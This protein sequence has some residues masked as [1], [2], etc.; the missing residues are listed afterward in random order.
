MRYT[1]LGPSGLRVSEIC[2]GTMSF[3]D[4][5]G[6]GADEKE[7]HRILVAYA[8]A[9]GNFI[10]IAN[11]YHEG[12]SEEIVGSFLGSERDRCVVASKYTL[13]M[14]DGDPNAAGNSR[15]N[16]R[17]SVE[18]SLR[19]LRTDYLDVLWVHAWDYATPVEEVMRGLEDLVRAG[20][21]NYVALSDAPAW[22]ASQANTLAALRGWSPFVA[23]QLEYSLI[24]RTGER[25]LLPVAEAFG[26]AVTAWAP[27][28]G[29]VL[30]GKYSRGSSDT[31]AD[32][33]RAE[34]NQMRLTERNLEIAHQVDAV[35]D[36]LS[37][38][39]AQVAIAWVR[40]RRERIIPIVGVRTL[41]QLEDI[42]GLTALELSAE[43]ISRLDEVS[44]IEASHT[45][46]SN[47]HLAR[48]STAT[49]S[50]GSSCRVRHRIGGRRRR[51]PRTCSPRSRPPGYS[52]R[53]GCDDP[54]RA[55]TGLPDA[56]RARVLDHHRCRQLALVLAR[57]RSHRAGIP[58]GHA[59]R[60]GTPDPP[61]L[62]PRG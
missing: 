13:A 40:Q 27:M 56:G 3:G 46:F 34:R 10:D 9:G 30:S 48:W 25:E 28:G 51:R 16:M 62:S 45:T 26:L 31:P 53:A 12:Q 36:E 41:E 24:E 14:R 39:S 49:S 61:A 55:R 7:S 52:R 2:L 50:Q 19:R 21:V 5:W 32:T 11:K 43:H 44:R 37:T 6:F 60:P 18:A 4:A 59:R 57:P 23:L 47:R 8:E 17:Q 58:L 42:L 22:I 15:K 35:A 20:K 29:G 54:H 1:L 38:S 33:M